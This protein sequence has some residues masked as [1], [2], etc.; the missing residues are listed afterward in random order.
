MAQQQA[1][2]W[3]FTHA[4]QATTVGITSIV[5]T[6]AS[7]LV[8]ASGAHGYVADQP[9]SIQG[10]T[11]AGWTGGYKIINVPSTTTFTIN[12]PDYK[13]TLANNGANGNIYSAAYLDMIRIEQALWDQTTAETSLLITDVNGFPMWNP[14]CTVADQ[15]YNYGKLYWIQGLVL[16]TLPSGSNL[17]M[18]IN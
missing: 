17:Q 12:V 13:Q 18:T 3:S 14:H 8:T 1:N 5:R 2:V 6:G 11:V 15:P 16:V 4:D 9:I 10:T 7:A